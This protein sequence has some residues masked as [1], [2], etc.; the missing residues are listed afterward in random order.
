VLFP[1]AATDAVDAAE[2]VFAPSAGRVTGTVLIVD[3]EP[4]VR[5]LGQ[6]VLESVGLRVIT[7]DDGR[8]GLDAFLG[9]VDELTA[10]VVDLTM[11]HMDGPE[12]AGHIRA[13]APGLPVLLMSGYSE[14]EVSA[15]VAGR[16]VSGFIQKPFAPREF[17]ARV[18]GALGQPR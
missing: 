3:D 11:P 17:I 13:T 2:R 10:A 7:A 4:A 16:H 18:L 14:H 9:H 6:L 1:A 5:R 8:A 15:R 12:L